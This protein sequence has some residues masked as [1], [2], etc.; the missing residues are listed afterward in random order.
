MA[1]TTKKKTLT[2]KT[3]KAAAKTES[4]TAQEQLKL[5]AETEAKENNSREGTG[6][7]NNEK[8]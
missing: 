7:T 2:K 8:D 4:K 6:K 5:T 3:A 1:K